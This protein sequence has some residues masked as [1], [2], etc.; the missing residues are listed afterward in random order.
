MDPGNIGNAGNLDQIR[1]LVADL[2]G[3]LSSGGGLLG[4]AAAGDLAEVPDEV[5]RVVKDTGLLARGDPRLRQPYR[6]RPASPPRLRTAVSSPEDATEL[7]GRLW[8]IDQDAAVDLLVGF[9]ESNRPR[10]Q[11]SRLLR[12]Q[13]QQDPQ[14]TFAE[15][16]RLAGP[17]VRW[18]TNTDLTRW[19][20]VTQH[21]FDAIIVAAGNGVIVTLI[22]FDG[23]E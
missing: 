3:P 1:D 15:L 14:D 23:G 8:E 9:A 18:W 20:P 7:M 13:H 16:A 12:R 22:A 17:D 21:T 19:N 10:R 2:G 6:L 4:W 5:F 11:G